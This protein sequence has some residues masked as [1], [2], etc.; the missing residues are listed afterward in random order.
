MS[1]RFRNLLKRWKTQPKVSSIPHGNCR[2]WTE[3]K[4]PFLSRAHT[5]QLATSLIYTM[6]DHPVI[7]HHERTFPTPS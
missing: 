4:L 5:P 7:C 1:T 2:P 3:Q 6:I